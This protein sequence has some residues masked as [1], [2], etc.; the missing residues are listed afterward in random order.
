[1]A[2]FEELDLGEFG[3]RVPM[4]TFE[5]VADEAVAIG[6]M[7]RDVSSGLIDAGDGRPLPG[8][9]AHGASVGDSIAALVELCGVQLAERDGRLHSPAAGPPTLIGKEELGLRC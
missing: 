2:I 8:Y 5:V 7:L 9:A 4:L 3:G 6:D 1:M